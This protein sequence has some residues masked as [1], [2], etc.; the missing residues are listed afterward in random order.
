[1]ATTGTPIGVGMALLDP[2]LAAIVVAALHE[3]GAAGFLADGGLMQ[4]GAVEQIVDQEIG[5]QVHERAA[6]GL[7]GDRAAWQDRAGR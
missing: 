1:M 7:E 5:F 2:R 4:F 6:V 3:H